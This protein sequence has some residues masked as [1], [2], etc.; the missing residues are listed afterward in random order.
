MPQYLESL[1]SEF[2]TFH[3]KSENLIF[4]KSGLRRISE[5]SRQLW[6]TFQHISHCP[7]SM[8]FQ[9][10]LSYHKHSSNYYR[11]SGIFIFQSK[12]LIFSKSKLS[13][14]LDKILR[15]RFGWNLVQTFLT[16]NPP[17]IFL[18]ISKF[19]FFSPKTSFSQNRDLE[20]FQGVGIEYLLI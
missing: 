5:H 13:H 14:I 4:S 15:A 6:Y 20:E 12:N 19:L 17:H 9:I 8:K 7:I 11:N 3:F 10:K 2:Q 1:F 18:G 16:T